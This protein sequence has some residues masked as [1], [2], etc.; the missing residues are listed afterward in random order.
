[1]GSS[2]HHH[3]HSS[4]LVPRGSH[5][6]NLT[7]QST[8]SYSLTPAE[9][10][11]VAELT[12]ELAAAYGSF[13]DPVLLRDLPRLAARLPE[14]VQDFLREFKLADRHGHTVIRGH[15]FDQRR[16]GPTP[17]HWRGRVRP[18]PEFPEELLLML[19]SALLG[20]P[21][22]WATQQDGHLVHDIFPI[23]SHENDQLG[24]GS[25]QLLTWHTEAAFHPYRSDYLILGALRNPDHVPTTV[26]ELDLSSLSAEDIDVL[27]E[28][29][30]HIAPDES[31]LP[32]NNTIATEEEAARFATIQRMID[33]RPLG[34]LLYGSRLDPYMRLDPYFT[35]VPQD[36]TDARRAYDALFKVVDSGMR[37]VVA[38]QGDVLFIDNHRA[39]HGR[40][41]FQARYD[42][43]DRWLKRVCVTS[44][45]R[46]SREMRATSATRLLG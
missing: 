43:T 21:F 28:P 7:D 20:E 13:G 40:L 27:F 9:A 1:M 23:R 33:E 2:H 46:R 35:S 22:G 10:S 30:Y 32:K 8:P 44:D 3:H 14:G 36:D 37:E 18:G 29:R 45:L 41:P 38:D 24:M 17:D 16:I 12:L 19:Y 31:H 42:G 39:V 34:P 6:S 11:A 25:K 15:D 26:G 4:G 5:M